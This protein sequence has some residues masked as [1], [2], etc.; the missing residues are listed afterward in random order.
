MLRLQENTS[1]LCGFDRETE[2]SQELNPDNKTES[3]AIEKQRSF[4]LLL[5]IYQNGDKQ[6]WSS[7]MQEK[8]GDYQ[9]Q[10]SYWPAFLT[11]N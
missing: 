10:N 2:S 7:S 6:L 3:I 5:N 9:P 1:Q 4:S 11:G 8:R